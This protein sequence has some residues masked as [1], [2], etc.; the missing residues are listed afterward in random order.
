M[1][2]V[3]NIYKSM[4]RRVSGAG[5]ALVITLA[6]LVG[7]LFALWE[8]HLLGPF[9]GSRSFNITTFVLAAVAI[10]FAS[11]QFADSRR[12]SRKMED[13]AA[14]MSTRYIGIFPKDM[15]DIIEVVNIADRQL[16][17]M[18]DFVDYG[19]YSNPKEHEEFMERINEA[20]DRGVDVRFLVYGKDPA[21]TALKQ[22]FPAEQWNREKAGPQFDHFFSIY[23]GIRRPDSHEEFLNILRRKEREATSQLLDKGVGIRLLPNQEKLFFWLEDDEDAVFSFENIGTEEPL[24]FRTRDAKI[25]ETFRCLF[26]RNWDSAKNYLETMTT[27]E[28][29]PQ[30]VASR[31]PEIDAL[32]AHTVLPGST[33]LVP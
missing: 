9:L 29:A 19:H 3:A 1:R 28:H 4:T 12:H 32:P 30:I 33:P 15:E 6:L 10:I 27:R 2:H 17:V 21:T 18:A 31:K 13:I 7:T 23:R 11:I 24:C 25:I 5:I 14:S 8:L 22:Q 26:K 20:R 16:I